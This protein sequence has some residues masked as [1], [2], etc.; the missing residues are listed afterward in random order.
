VM[1]DF[2]ETGDTVDCV[3][4]DALMPEEA[5]ASLALHLKERGI[6]V[7]MISGSPEAMKYAMDNGLQLL[8]ESFRSQELTV[9]STSRS[10][11][12]SSDSDHK[13]TA[14]LKKDER[15]RQCPDGMCL[16]GPEPPRL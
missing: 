14:E 11:A 13:A 2:M 9:P 3:I 7:V 16:I 15:K 8:R 5:S 12:V 1:R 4:L 10:P 6:P